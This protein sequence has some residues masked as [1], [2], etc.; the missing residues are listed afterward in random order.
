MGWL[1]MGTPNPSPSTAGCLVL[2]EQ[3]RIHPLGY[4]R[5]EPQNAAKKRMLGG[6][7][8]PERPPQPPAL[9][10]HL[11][12][13][14]PT[15]PLPYGGA[16][17]PTPLPT[18]HICTHTHTLI[19]PLPHTKQGSSHTRSTPSLLLPPKTPQPGRARAHLLSGS[20]VCLPKVFAAGGTCF[21]TISS[22]KE[23]AHLA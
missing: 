23:A 4:Q 3:G 11:A 20:P 2:P 9:G 16:L 7:H 12:P 6:N 22:A 5:A 18:P 10:H 1:S 14:A 8:L 17:D 19:F 15:S 21:D 13:G